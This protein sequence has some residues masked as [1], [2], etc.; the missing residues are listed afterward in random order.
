M[1]LFL[2]ATLFTYCTGHDSV[3]G[4][5]QSIASCQHLFL[6]LA[7]S[8]CPYCLPQAT[9]S[10]DW[11]ALAAILVDKASSQDEFTRITAIKWIKVMVAWQLARY[12]KSAACIQQ[13]LRQ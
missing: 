11:L 12:A 10:V 13:S 9:P 7:D 4:V 3:Y 6:L 2:S 8:N 5:N 1:C